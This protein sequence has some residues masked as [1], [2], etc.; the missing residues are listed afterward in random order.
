MRKSKVIDW[1]DGCSQTLAPLVANGVVITGTSGGEHGI[2]GFIDGWDPATGKQLWRTYT[3]PGPG[4]PG[5]DTWPGD[6]WKHGGSSTWITGSY[7][8]EL[9]T[10][11]WGTGNAGPWNATVRHPGDNLYTSSVLALEPRTGKIEWH[12][13]FS[14]NDPYDYD[15]VADMVLADIDVG[16]RPRR[17]W[18][19]SA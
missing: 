8:P 14:P 7:D 9:D 18:R 10:V 4:E 15:A 16:G 1:K 19:R 13:Q 11:Y 5:H 6:T 17:S 3:I 2:R 12:F